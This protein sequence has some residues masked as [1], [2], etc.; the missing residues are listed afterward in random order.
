[1][2][3]QELIAEWKRDE[4][5]PFAG[6]DFSY[7][8]GRC[9]E[10]S[11]PWD[12]V[13]LARALVAK[14]TCLLDIQ[15]GG[16]EILASLAPFPGKAFAVEGYEPNVAVA[17]QRLAPFGV[18]VQGRPERSELP[19]EDAM[20]DLVLNRHGGL[21]FPLIARVLRPGGAFLT[22]QVNGTSLAGLQACF[23]AAPK[24]PESTLSNAIA[25]AQAAGLEIVHAEAWVGRTVFRDVGALVYFLK[26][27]PWLVDDFSVDGH[28][29]ALGRLQGEL[30]A[31]GQL[32]FSSSRYLLQ[33]RK[34]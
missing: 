7:I 17:R 4:Q 13:A 27:I 31:A 10:E 1:M 2:T 25:N 14:S 26:A 5:A 28:L 11:P 9:I 12:Y 24:W 18:E 16:G 21:R 3:A 19:F 32:V 34:P 22:Q 30:E 6:W 33:A 29:A 15:T 8:D 23:G 20:F